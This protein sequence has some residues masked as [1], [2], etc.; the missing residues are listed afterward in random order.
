M[1]SVASGVPSPSPTPSPTPTPFPI[2]TA[3]PTPSPGFEVPPVDA[4]AATL[5]NLSTGQVLFTLHPYAHRP[6]A[7]VTKLMTALVVSEHA[8]PDD[9][10]RVGQEAALEGSSGPGFSELGLQRG[11]HLTV[12]QL[13]YAL[14]LPSAN[15]AAVALAD[16][17]S[18]SSKRFVK[19]MNVEAGDLGLQ[20]TR[21]YSPNGL[22]DRGYSTPHDLAAIAEEVFRVRFLEKI[23]QTKFRDIPS[24]G[25]P[26][27]HVQNRNVL[28]WLY[29]G[30]L[31]GK[32]GYTEAAGYC[33]VAGAERGGRRLLAV[34]LGEPTSEDSFTDVA[35]LLNYGFHAFDRETVVD[36]DTRLSGLRVGDELLSVQTHAAL[37]ALVLADV[38][39]DPRV[40]LV[41]AKD[42]RPPFRA[43]DRVGWVQATFQG[44]LL[45]R[46]PVFVAGVSA[47]ASSRAEPWWEESVDLLV[48]VSSDVLHALFG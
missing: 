36:E 40:S 1:P 47:G 30:T 48:Q 12:R 26:P 14:L 8:H 17:V 34:V 42:A 18:G 24:L 25:G 32:T 45:G 38:R 41:A 43:G 11:E 2:P 9:V 10:V 7:S 22:D 44:E 23:L 29:K 5:V 37:R 6:I 21:F 4:N 39:T 3:L 27:R 15:D 28:L 16:A 31:G 46:A 19:L 13:L 33:L 20:G 35:A